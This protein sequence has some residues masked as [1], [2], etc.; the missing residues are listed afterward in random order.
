MFNSLELADVN[1]KVE[2]KPSARGLLQWLLC[3]TLVP[4]VA[5][6]HV[7]F[8]PPKTYANPARAQTLDLSPQRASYVALGTVSYQTALQ[9]S[10]QFQAEVEQFL[11]S[12]STS[13]MSVARES[14][15]KSRRP[16][17]QTEIFRF[18]DGPIDAPAI[19]DRPEGPET[20]LNAWPVDE[21]T[22]DYVV[23]ARKSGLIARKD[24]PLTGEAIRDQDQVADESAITTGWHAIE[25]LLWGQ[26]LAKDGP[27]TRSYRDYLPGDPIRERRR[28][29]LRLVT[30]MLVSDLEQVN[31]AWS[32]NTA[33]NFRSQLLNTPPIE[34]LG[35]SLHG[36]TSYV[37]I[38]LFAE[39]FA[40]AMD[41]GSQEDEHSCFSD[42]TLLDLQSGLKGVRN[43]VEAR[44]EG[45][46]LG[47]SLLDLL[48]Y[49]DPALANRIRKNLDAADRGVAALNIPFDQ[50]I[51]TPA[52]H[53]QRIAAEQTLSDIRALAQGLKAASEAL[54]VQIVVPGI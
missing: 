34:V 23:G 20:H 30:T 21:S 22:I 41:S 28:E 27:G 3:L 42:T 10:R 19:G 43:M 14:W 38:E 31:A 37:A 7:V 39:R 16:Y 48:D 33:P 51:L 4:Q 25:F 24:F 44:Y 53:P 6:A 36:A 52:D 29:Y 2:A 32:K 49:Q 35:R 46:K 40:V 15:V 18:N 1:V 26:D 54:G 45:T 5:D 9:A 12:P 8:A 13:T 11:A 50:L 17:I 47:A